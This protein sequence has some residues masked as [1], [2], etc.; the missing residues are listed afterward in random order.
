MIFQIQWI[1]EKKKRKLPANQEN[2][3]L[4][5]HEPKRKKEDGENNEVKKNDPV[6]NI[7]RNTIK[8]PVLSE[9]RLHRHK[10]TGHLW[11]SKTLTPN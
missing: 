2:N 7:R 11:K 8:L 5:D 4:A 1:R 3:D 10:I 9:N 6:R